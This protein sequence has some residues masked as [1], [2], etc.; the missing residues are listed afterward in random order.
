M[1][2]ADGPGTLTVPW[3]DA[4]SNTMS[5]L[6]A[7]F[8]LWTGVCTISALPSFLCAQ[9]EYDPAGMVSGVA[10][11]I[12]AYT[13]VTGTRVFQRLKAQPFVQLTLYIGFATRLAVSLMYPF[14]MACD[15]WT[16]ALSIE[17][18]RRFVSD[19]EAFLGTLAITILQGIFLNIILVAYMGVVYRIQRAFCAWP[20]REGFC[21]KCGYDLTGNVSGVCPECGRPI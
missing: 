4:M 18:V 15:I 2:E 3:R 9:H 20:T 21:V 10:V 8:L 1:W 19:P 17:I 7:R 11:F 13:G 5:T 14:G 12:L 6:P 16:G